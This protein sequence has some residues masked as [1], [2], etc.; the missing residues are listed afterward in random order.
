M[1]GRPLALLLI[2]AGVLLILAGVATY[3]GLLSRFGHLPGDIRM[4]RGNVR[5]YAP[6]TSMLVVSVLASLI[7]WLVRHFK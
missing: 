7:L 6:I 1:S 2:G 4:E 5:L 3:F